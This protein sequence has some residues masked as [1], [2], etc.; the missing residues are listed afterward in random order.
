MIARVA[1]GAGAPA[2]RGRFGRRGERAAKGSGG[3]GHRTVVVVAGEGGAGEAAITAREPT[4][5]PDKAGDKDDGATCDEGDH[6]GR[7][8]I[9][10]G[11]I[12]GDADGS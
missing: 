8:G 2:P 5:D 6:G 9:S 3:R 11:R 7:H 4:C 12:I 10:G 1:V